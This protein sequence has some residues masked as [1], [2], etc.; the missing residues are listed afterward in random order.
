MDYG[1][2]TGADARVLEAIRHER[3][4]YREA[5]RSSQD[6]LWLVLNAAAGKI[7]VSRKAI[8]EYDRAHAAIEASHDI[9]T[10]ANCW[11]ALV[12]P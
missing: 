12:I 10:G 5:L 4:Q 7:C 9:A 2:D 1:Y 8:I 6:T 3:D 11:E